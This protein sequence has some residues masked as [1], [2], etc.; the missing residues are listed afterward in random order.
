MRLPLDN[1]AVG[2]PTTMHTGHKLD[3]ERVLV[4]EAVLEVAEVEEDKSCLGVYSWSGVKVRG[5]MRPYSLNAF[6]T[7]Y[8]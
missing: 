2:L 1:I 8:Q 7:F 5:H 6:I 4:V 3:H